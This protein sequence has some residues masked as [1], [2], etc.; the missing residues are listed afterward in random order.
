MKPGD[1]INF[2]GRTWTVV[3]VLTPS[4]RWRENFRS[5]RHIFMA[6][7]EGSGLDCTITY[8]LEHE[9]DV[10]AG[11]RA[12]PTFYTAQ[13]ISLI[14]LD[15]RPMNVHAIATYRGEERPDG[16][17]VSLIDP[18]YEG[19]FV[20]MFRWQLAMLEQHGEPISFVNAIHNTRGA[21]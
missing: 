19:P 3:F 16:E 18:D 15:D 9:D 20:P 6:A 4:A 2:E 10:R 14:D 21:A 11:W 17:L 8:R 1:Y 7:V 5:G 12:G 13:V